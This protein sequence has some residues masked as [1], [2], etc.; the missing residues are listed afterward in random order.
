[1][2]LK[3][4]KK[5]LEARLP[6][7]RDLTDFNWL[8]NLELATEQVP[9]SEEEAKSWQDAL[10]K[11]SSSV[12]FPIAYETNE[13]MTW[14][15][16][17][18]G[19]ICV[20]FNGIGEHTFEINCNK[21]QLHW[22]KRFLL[23]QETKKNSK[24][25]HS[26]SLFTLRSGLILW[27]ETDKKGKP[28]NINYLALHCC[29]DTRLWTAE[30][31]QVV[32]EERAEE[33]TRIISNAKKKDN[34]NKNQ[35]AFIKRKQTTLAR[36]NNPYPRPSKPLYKGQSNIILGVCFG[37]KERATIAVVDTITGK[38]LINKSTKQLLG[39]NYRLI[40]RQRQ[41]KR[42]LSHQRKIAQTQSKPN[43]FKESNLGE[44]IDRLLSKAI[45]KVAKKYFAGSIALPNVNGMRDQ[46]NSEI[47]AK[48]EQ[49]CP[50]C[51]EAQEKYAK[52][53]RINVNNWSYGRLIKSIQ[54]KAS[55]VGIA[56]EESKQSLKG[57]PEEKAKELA[58]TAY[59]SRNKL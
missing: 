15:K 51:I 45:I 54:N 28:W 34:L 55:Q 18:K 31:T 53:Y 21:R 36:I 42:K 10:L 58:L 52:Q 2:K 49:K 22:F 48:A 13:D 33:I 38:V 3:T 8:N 6:K 1:M 47:Q 9:E 41:Q 23:D 37:L 20:K 11:K 26:S 44:Y 19:R 24:N 56:I 5:K 57:S 12:P 25:Q 59:K 27:Q 17:E 43:N 40:D 35:L 16:N 29:V 4:S 46:I 50:E 32:A 39:E 7:A 14:F 30:G